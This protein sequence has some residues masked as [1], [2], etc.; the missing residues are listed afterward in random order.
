ML[1]QT[2][3]VR[4]QS[5]TRELLLFIALVAAMCAGISAARPATPAASLFAT[6]LSAQILQTVFVVNLPDRAARKNWARGILVGAGTSAG[7]FVID[8]ARSLLAL[9]PCATFG[10]TLIPFAATTVGLWIV[11][12]GFALT[13]GIMGGSVSLVISGSRGRGVASIAA[14]GVWMLIVVIAILL[15]EP[16]P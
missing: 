6:L 13:C 3:R 14:L 9:L 8:G 1:T 5:G 2:V 7:L 10:N 12:I 16:K 4:L 11:S 15:R